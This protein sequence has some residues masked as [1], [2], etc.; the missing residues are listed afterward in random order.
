M[1]TTQSLEF[2]HAFL[3]SFL[4]TYLNICLLLPETDSSL[5]LS[6]HRLSCCNKETFLLHQKKQKQKNSKLTSQTHIRQEFISLWTV[7]NRSTVR[8]TSDPGVFYLVTLP[9]QLEAGSS[10]PHL[11]SPDCTLQ[12]K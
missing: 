6:A 11:S 12:F 9:S 4:Y 10:A 5:H 3:W 1:M 7:Q 8:V 2:Y